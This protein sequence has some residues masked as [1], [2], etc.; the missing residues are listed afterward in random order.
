MTQLLLVDLI[1]IQ[2]S[3]IPNF[4]VRDQLIRCLLSIPSHIAEG[5]GRY[6][7][8]EFSR[9]LKIS[10]GSCY[11]LITQLEVIRESELCKNIEID[12][13]VKEANLIGASL[14]ARIKYPDR[15]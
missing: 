2:I 11:E 12:K 6:S 10:L 14:T 7:R 1:F 13:V 5:Y 9:Y 3:T 8:K 4:I 15:E